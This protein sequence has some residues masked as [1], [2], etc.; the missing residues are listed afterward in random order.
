MSYTKLGKMYVTPNVAELE[1]PERS[2]LTMPIFVTQI[3][4]TSLDFR[5]PGYIKVMPESFQDIL[6]IKAKDKQGFSAS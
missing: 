4:I 1:I 3:S 2:P 5:K 6:M